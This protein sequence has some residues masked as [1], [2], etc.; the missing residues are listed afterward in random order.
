MVAITNKVSG[1]VSKS[2][3]YHPFSNGEVICN[4]FYPTTDCMTVNGPI[5]VY[6]LNGEAKVYVP[7]N[8]KAWFFSSSSYYSFFVWSKIEINRN[9]FY[10]LDIHIINKNSSMEKICVVCKT[11]PKKYKCPKCKSPYC[12]IECSNVH[13]N[14]CS[15]LNLNKK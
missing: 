12:S 6:L 15:S 5:N 9:T 2:V 14:E 8:W 13:K 10:R 11:H 3:S 4:I 1:G 7:K